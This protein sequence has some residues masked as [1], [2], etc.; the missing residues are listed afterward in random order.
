MATTRARL[1]ATRVPRDPEGVVLVLHGGAS[2]TARAMVSPAQLSV[3]R[4]VPVAGRIAHAGRGR[5]AVYR[6]LNSHRGWDATTTPVMDVAWAL[7]RIEESH[8]ALPAALVGHSLGGRAALLAADR[9]A[10]R[11]VVALNPWVYPSDSADL[12]GR[13]VL[14]VH[15]TDD[16]VASPARA[17]TVARRL[18]ATARVGYVAVPGGRHA[19]LR[20]GATFERY[21]AEFVTATLLGTEPT[22]AAVSTVLAGEDFT[23]VEGPP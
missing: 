18:S 21:A 22:S 4:M 23:R 2:R 16:R 19:M 10:V 7:T 14:V 5:L 12:T 17:A 8:G 1:V 6:L 3:L 9:P 13:Q 15:G 20:H 11:S